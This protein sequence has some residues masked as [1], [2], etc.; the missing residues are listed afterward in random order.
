MWTGSNCDGNQH[1]HDDI[2]YPGWYG[3]SQENHS[4]ELV[5]NRKDCYLDPDVAR[6]WLKGKTCDNDLAF[7]VYGAAG[8][9]HNLP[10]FTCIEFRGQASSGKPSAVGVS[11]PDPTPQ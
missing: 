10:A 9:V 1:P 11:G 2:S 6:L 3:S 7:Y 5:M 8:C 4:L